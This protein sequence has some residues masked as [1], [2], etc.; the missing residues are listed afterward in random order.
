MGLTRALRTTPFHPHPPRCLMLLNNLTKAEVRNL[1]SETKDQITALVQ[2]FSM[3]LGP[4]RRRTNPKPS[5]SAM[6]MNENHVERHSRQMLSFDGTR[7]SE[8]A[9]VEVFWSCPG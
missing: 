9:H 8:L 1:Y 2:I 4:I 6:F 7:S 3:P 5:F